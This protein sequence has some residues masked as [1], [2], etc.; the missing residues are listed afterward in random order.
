MRPECKPKASG[1]PARPVRP[2][3]S[4]HTPSWGMSVKQTLACLKKGRTLWPR[5]QLANWK[6]LRAS[7]RRLTSGGPWRF[8]QDPK[9][10]VKESRPICHLLAPLYLA[11]AGKHWRRPRVPPHN[12]S[13]DPTGSAPSPWPRGRT[14]PPHASSI[15]NTMTLWLLFI[16]KQTPGPATGP[17]RAEASVVTRPHLKLST[18]GRWHTRQRQSFP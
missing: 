3:R 1:I 15:H 13:Q 18:R 6:S 8:L 5:H 10:P 7:P 16:S 11:T 17:E 2:L 9:A 12:L 4:G 14:A